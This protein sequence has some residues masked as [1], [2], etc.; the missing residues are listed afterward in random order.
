MPSE[1]ST[2]SGNPI[3]PGWYADPEGIIFANEY[4]IYP[5][6]SDD[7]ERPDRST[8]FSAQQLA[9]Q[10]NTINQQYLKQTFINAFYVEGPFVFKRKNKYYFMWSEGGWTG[11][12]YSVAYAIGDSP[13]GPFNRIGKILQRDS[14]IATGA[15]HHSVITIPNTDERY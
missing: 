6:Y 11:P 14:T 9:A 1:T 8:E 15:G 12:D 13:L 2:Y 7:Y 10:K 4:W 5:T 3:L